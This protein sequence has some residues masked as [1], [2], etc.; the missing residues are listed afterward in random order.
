MSSREMSRKNQICPPRG[1]IFPKTPHDAAGPKR[2]KSQNSSLEIKCTLELSQRRLSRH[3][4]NRVMVVVKGST[5][6]KT[7]VMT[8]KTVMD[9]AA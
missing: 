3:R 7:T 6:V 1:R 8:P 4:I 5:A 9:S 2:Q